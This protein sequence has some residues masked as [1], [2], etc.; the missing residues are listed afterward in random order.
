MWK[1]AKG[2]ATR[3][4]CNTVSRSELEQAVVCTLIAEVSMTGTP[5]GVGFELANVLTRREG[6]VLEQRGDGLHE[7]DPI[8]Q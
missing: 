1:I 4:I 8:I 2:S 6:E 7:A 5:T 3:L